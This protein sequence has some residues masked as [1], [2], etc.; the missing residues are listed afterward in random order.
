MRKPVLDTRVHE[1]NEHS[2]P[3]YLLEAIRAHADSK[4]TR[5]ASVF[6]GPD[7]NDSAGL[8]YA[9][10][11]R[12]IDS[13][14]AWLTSA[15]AEGQRVLLAFPPGIE[16]VV[17]FL[18]CLQSGSIAVPVDGAV[19]RRR[20]VRTRVIAD[21]CAAAMVLSTTPELAAH[22]LGG[23]T[24]GI[25]CVGMAEVVGSPATDQAC[26]KTPGDQVAML[27]YTS[28]STGNPRGVRVT[29]ENLRAN[30]AATQERFRVTEASRLVSWLPHFHD[31]GL[32]GGILQALYSGCTSWNFSP[33]AFAQRPL[34][35][36]QVIS[37]VRAT[38][39]GA[40]NFAYEHCVQRIRSEEMADL[41]LSSWT[42]AYVGGEPV[43]PR[44]LARFSESFR[45][46]G[47]RESSFLPCYGLAEAT[48]LA[49]GK[50]ATNSPRFR[51][52][53]T[54]ETT[55]ELVATP[56]PLQ[57]SCGTGLPDHEVAI[58][59]P[60]SRVRCEQGAQ[61]EIWLA[62][63]SVADGYWDGS[64]TSRVEFTAT[65]V[66]EPDSPA[67]LRTGDV[68]VLLDGELYV[69]GR[70]K[71]MVIVD[72]RNHYAEDIE[73]TAEDA[74]PELSSGQSAAFP[75]H[76][77]DG[78]RLVIAVEMTRAQWRRIRCE[79]GDREIGNSSFWNEVTKAIQHRVSTEL[80][81]R[82]HDVVPAP[83]Y[84]F[85]RTSS[86]KVIRRFCRDRYRSDDWRVS[87]AMTMHRAVKILREG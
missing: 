7:L 49:T 9:E 22:S 58:V 4:P 24:E 76:G 83:P 63:P 26:R 2:E 46:C 3:P 82:V 15:G 67:F 13:A 28:G 78:E 59:D 53:P 42:V 87:R 65:I 20:S 30:L 64:S 70:L 37:R 14:T 50:E 6:L 52:I 54:R 73:R 5:E 44:T 55:S 57:V 10:L 68:G 38:I 31:M 80:G 27:Q 74:H 77:E 51:S 60:D 36:L 71:D 43:R 56:Q 41:D 84:S 72:G 35:W 34:R 86:G 17:A 12:N 62:G 79:V 32:I 21:N 29:H 66:S 40:P 75:V 81:L 45:Q 11:V 16:F 1:N 39:S 85:P 25:R 19:T 47:F 23:R 69:T 61:G 18:S 33:F 48:L 8:T